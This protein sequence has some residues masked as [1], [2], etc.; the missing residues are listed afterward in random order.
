MSMVE[1]PF[2]LLVDDN[3]AT[4]TLITAILQKE[5]TTD[6]ASDGAEAVEKLKTKQYAVILLDIRMPTFD[7]YG[8]LDYLTANRPEALK[9]VIV[10]TASLSNR[11]LARMKQYDVFGMIAKPFD[12]EVLLAAVKQCAGL[13]D[14]SSRGSAFFNSTMVLLLADLLQKRLM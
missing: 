8:V 10:V 13:G 2:V 3:E 6:T 7:G 5:F 4:C 14:G 1:K 12:V 11:E 9:S